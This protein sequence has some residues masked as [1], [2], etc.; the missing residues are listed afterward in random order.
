[1]IRNVYPGSRIRIFSPSLTRIP[2]PGIRNTG[3]QYLKN[4]SKDFFIKIILYRT[5]DIR[6]NLFGGISSEYILTNS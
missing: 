6:F 5:R 2:D 1:M 3:H 4:H